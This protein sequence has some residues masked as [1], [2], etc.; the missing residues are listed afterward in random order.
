MKTKTLPL[1]KMFRGN[2]TFENPL[3]WVLNLKKEEK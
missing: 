3:I 2:K 1:L